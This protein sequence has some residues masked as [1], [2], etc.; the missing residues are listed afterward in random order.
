VKLVEQRRATS[1]EDCD[2]VALMLNISSAYRKPHTGWQHHIALTGGMAYSESARTMTRRIRRILVV[3]PRVVTAVIAKALGYRLIRR[4]HRG[5]LGEAGGAS[6]EYQNQ[7]LRE[8]VVKYGSEEG[9]ARWLATAETT[10][11]LGVTHPRPVDV[12]CPARRTIA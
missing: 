10:S 8:A 9:A 12:L 7:L 4:Q 2:V 5:A 11:T 6:P 1:V 3:G